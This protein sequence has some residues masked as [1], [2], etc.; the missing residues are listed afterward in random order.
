VKEKDPLE[1][2]IDERGGVVAVWIENE[3]PVA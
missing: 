2:K 3:E 1:L